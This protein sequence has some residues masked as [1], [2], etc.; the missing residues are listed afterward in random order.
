MGNCALR[1]KK[2]WPVRSEQSKSRR[3]PPR[4]DRGTLARSSELYAA[5][6]TKQRTMTMTRTMMHTRDSLANEL[7]EWAI[8]VV[9]T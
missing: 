6:A 9:A 7:V 3:V 1:E 8:S 2:E 5:T 4:P